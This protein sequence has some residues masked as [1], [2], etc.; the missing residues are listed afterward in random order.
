VPAGRNAARRRREAAL[1]KLAASAGDTPAWISADTL[2]HATLV[3]ASHNPCLASIYQSV[4]ETLVNCEYRNRIG[5]GTVPD[6]LRPSE[7]AGPAAPHEPILAGS[8]EPAA[9]TPG[10]SRR[11]VRK[12]GDGR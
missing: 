10:D 1:R 11:Q 3:R 6:W 7:A 4:H 5:S 9:P 2:F 8:L 12:C